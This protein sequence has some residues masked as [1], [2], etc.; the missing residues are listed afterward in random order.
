MPSMPDYDPLGRN[1]QPWFGPKRFGYGY[2]PRTWPGWLLVAVSVAAT[3][4]VATTT[5]SPLAPL[6]MLPVVVIGI[7]SGARSR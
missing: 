5:H 4:L 7:I 2:G 6:I 3:I 1:K